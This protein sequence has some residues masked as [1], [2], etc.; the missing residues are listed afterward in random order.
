VSVG[1]DEERIAEALEAAL[2]RLLDDPSASVSGLGR[3]AGGASRQTWS[4]SL[5]RGDGPATPLVLRR[6]PPGATLGIGMAKEAALLVAAAEAGVAVPRVIASSDDVSLL[7]APFMVME[8]VDG[9]TIPR[10]ILRDDLYRAARGEMAAQCGRALARIHRIPLDVAA[11]LDDADQLDRQ[12]AMIDQLGQAHPAFEL[13]LR[14]LSRN[15]PPPTGRCV[16]HGDFRNGNL[17]VGPEG[18]RAV[19]DWELAHVGDPAEDL[20]WLC[21]RSWRFGSSLPVGGFGDYAELLS[22]Y[23]E[24]S[25]HVVELETLR[26]WEIFGTLRWGVI[27]IVQAFTHISGAV[28]SVELAAIGRRVCEVEWD[29]LELLESKP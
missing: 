26:W 17:V 19:L 9:E 14:W 20:G 11:G 10:R 7:G 27:C 24:E 29:L 13:A 21:V 5:R 3:M 1:A 18:L 6:D 22:A 8:R 4:F 12:L 2:R 16:V 23:A 15:R 25:G 28:R